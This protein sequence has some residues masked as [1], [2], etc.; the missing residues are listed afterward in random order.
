MAAKL[1]NAASFT[2]LEVMPLPPGRTTRRSAYDGK[3]MSEN[4]NKATWPPLFFAWLLAMTASLAA[5]FIGEVMGQAPCVLCWYQRAAMFPLAIVLGIACLIEDGGVWR[6]ALPLAII[7][8]A[9][10]LWH[11]LLYYG[12]IPAPLVP[13]GAGPSCSNT[14]MV[15]FGGIPIPS[16]ALIAFAGVIV[17]LMAVKRKAAT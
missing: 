17:C 7:G 14:D 11:N 3:R 1:D 4:S 12:L 6:Y 15:I 8:G 16:L 5:I 13:C 9:V 2:F 10:A